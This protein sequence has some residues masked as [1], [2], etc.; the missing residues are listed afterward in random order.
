MT[1]KFF[2]LEKVV[3]GHDEDGD[4]ISSCV[5][6]EL[7]AEVDLTDEQK[8]VEALKFAEALNGELAKSEIGSKAKISTQAAKKAVARLLADGMVVID[9]VKGRGRPMEAVKLV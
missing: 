7:D 2:R 5:L 8:V 4:E 6:V 3:L 1:P 9:T